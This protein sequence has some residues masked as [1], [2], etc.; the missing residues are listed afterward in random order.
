MQKVPLIS[1]KRP[2][3]LGSTPHVTDIYANTSIDVDST[4]GWLGLAED[5]FR[6]R[7]THFAPHPATSGPVVWAAP[8]R[9]HAQPR[10]CGQR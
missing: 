10:A 3:I 8:N 5:T 4:N 2:Y 9:Y 6:R 1:V 7:P